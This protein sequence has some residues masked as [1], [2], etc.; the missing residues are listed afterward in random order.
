MPC[1]N[2]T[3]PVCW[4]CNHPLKRH[5]FSPVRSLR[6]AFLFFLYAPGNPSV[7]IQPLTSVSVSGMVKVSL[8]G[9]F[10]MLH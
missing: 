7:L 5:G 2:G 10:F 1:L 9:A 3:L 6:E 8:P 4:V